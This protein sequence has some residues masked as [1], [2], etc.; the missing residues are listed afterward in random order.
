MPMATPITR[1]RA[2]ASQ[3]QQAGRA[4]K[5][6]VELGEDG[7]EVDAAVI[8][9]GLKVNPDQ[10]LDQLRS[11]AITSRYERGV[12]EDAGRNR[13]TFFS[14]SRRLQIIVDVTGAIIQRRMIDF[15]QNPLPAATRSSVE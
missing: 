10:V 12:G 6:L 3:P 15:G 2:K 7:V 4:P 14:Q 13:L 8:A 11:G 9:S 5:R 1:I